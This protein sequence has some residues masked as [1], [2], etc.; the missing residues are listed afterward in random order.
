MKD[1]IKNYLKQWNEVQLFTTVTQVIKYTERH[2]IMN[3]Q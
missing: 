3:I 1:N 2:W